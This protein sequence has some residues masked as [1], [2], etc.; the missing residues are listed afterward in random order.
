MN[1]CIQRVKVN[2]KIIIFISFQI[3]GYGISKTIVVL[4]LL[5]RDS[6]KN[7]YFDFYSLLLCFTMVNSSLFVLHMEH[8]RYYK[9]RLYVLLLTKKVHIALQ[10]V[11]PICHTGLKIAL[12]LTFW[13]ITL[14]NLVW[15]IF[16]ILNSSKV[17]LLNIAEFEANLEHTHETKRVILICKRKC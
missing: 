11:Q 6:I 17:T 5:F 1:D 4:L 16:G 15:N 9:F 10:N 13:S 8:Q 3:W 7:H 2:Y 14:S 12:L